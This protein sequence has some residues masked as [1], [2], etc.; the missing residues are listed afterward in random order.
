L[1]LCTSEEIDMTGYMIA[2][3]QDNET[4]NKIC[5]SSDF[6]NS[7]LWKHPH[8]LELLCRD[9]DSL[10]KCTQETLQATGA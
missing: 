10:Y 8:L 4:P 1:F 7:L 5:M 3:A 2:S 6:L 9:P